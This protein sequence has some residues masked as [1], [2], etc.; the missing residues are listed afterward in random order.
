MAIKFFHKKQNDTCILEKNAAETAE[1]RKKS[2]VGI[3]TKQ[4]PKM[5]DITWME[6]P[7]GVQ[8]ALKQETCH[9]EKCHLMDVVVPSQ[10]DSW[11]FAQQKQQ[12]LVHIAKSAGRGKSPRP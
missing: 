2:S 8:T 9:L 3:K 12:K 6:E 7:V 4:E 10:S 5:A 1:A 11:K